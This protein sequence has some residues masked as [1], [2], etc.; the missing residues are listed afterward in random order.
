[1]PSSPLTNSDPLTDAH[2]I[3]WP[4][5]AEAEGPHGCAPQTG[6][7]R[8][9]VAAI[10]PYR[11]QVPSGNVFG[12][13]WSHRGDHRHAVGAPAQPPLLRD[14]GFLASQVPI[15]MH[16]P[17]CSEIGASYRSTSQVCTTGLNHGS[18]WMAGPVLGQVPSMSHHRRHTRRPYSY[19]ER[20]I[21][22]QC[23]KSMRRQSLKRHI[24]EVH[25]RIKR[26]V[27]SGFDSGT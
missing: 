17:T 15:W 12:R 25:N 26:H 2:L 18:P 24:R 21:C 9:N 14:T 11:S 13:A 8:L 19:P 23:Q 22:D 5:T 1:M 16:S 7:A 4:T 6:W 20:V 3:P 10:H 27:K